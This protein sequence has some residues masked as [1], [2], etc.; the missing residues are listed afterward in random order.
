[1]TLHPSL[2]RYMT[3]KPSIASIETKSMY[4]NNQPWNLQAI[5]A[6]AGV[7]KLINESVNCLLELG[8]N[9]LDEVD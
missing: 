6:N 4:G 3:R 9:N 1:M 8:N 5:G 7:V 2:E